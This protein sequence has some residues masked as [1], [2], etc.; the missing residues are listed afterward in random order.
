MDLA[1][2]RRVRRWQRL[3][4]AGLA[5]AGAIVAY[6]M[7]KP[8]AIR[9]LE[10]GAGASARWLE[11][12]PG[13]DLAGAFSNRADGLFQ[14]AFAPGGDPQIPDSY[15]EWVF[16]GSATGLAY[17]E[18][19][20]RREHDTPGAFTQVYL[21]PEAFRHFRETGEFPEGTTFVL[22]IRKPTTGISIA[23]D[24]WFAGELLAVH[25]AIKDTRRL[26]G[27]G[28]FHVNESGIARRARTDTCN[29]CHAEHGAV[30][31]VFV[32]FYPVLSEVRKNITQRP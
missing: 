29:S 12:A 32:Q 1:R 22:D 8:L 28:Y 4:P 23:R 16:V 13:P 17:G 26:G 14:P 25:A 18:P 6:P 27:W 19:G 31:N 2:L 24:G 15:R 30:D 11:A 3:L 20:A 7:L 9:A 21:E 10:L 5:L